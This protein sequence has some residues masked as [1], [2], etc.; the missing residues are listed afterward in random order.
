[1]PI[2]FVLVSHSAK[3]AEAVAEL[4]QEMAKDVVIVPVGGAAEGGFG[5]DPAAVLAACEKVEES[6][7]RVVLMAD[8][9]SARMSAE[10]AIEVT[11][12]APDGTPRRVLGPG[13]FLEGT[14]A[15]TARAQTGA[16]LADVVRAIATSLDFWKDQVAHEVASNPPTPH[17]GVAGFQTQVTVVDEQGLHA[18]PAAILA[19]L[20]SKEPVP[21]L[22]NGVEADSMMELLLLGIGQGQRVIVSTPDPRGEDSVKRVA[23]AI[24][25]GLSNHA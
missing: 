25:A 6:C 16:G 4:A 20:V 17:A 21:I 15:G 12:N 24:A 1:M 9:G 7:E 3:A 14:V 13:P 22:V 18:R 23:A 5:S 10:M 2:G 19:E 11:E 8:L